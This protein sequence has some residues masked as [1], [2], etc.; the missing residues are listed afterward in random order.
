MSLFQ[1]LDEVLSTEDQA[2]L[3]RYTRCCQGCGLPGLNPADTVCPLCGSTSWGWMAGGWWPPVKMVSTGL[4]VAWFLHDMWLTMTPGVAPLWA[5]LALGMAT[6]LGFLRWARAERFAADALPWSFLLLA[7]VSGGPVLLVASG[8]FPWFGGWLLLA[9]FAVTWLFL[10]HDQGL[11]AQAGSP[12]LT[13]VLQAIDRRRGRL[14]RNRV[15]VEDELERIGPV[16]AAGRLGELRGRLEYAR[17]MLRREM[18]DL[19]S[20]RE[21]TLVVWRFLFWKNC[22][23][24]LFTALGGIQAGDLDLAEGINRGLRAEI[25]RVRQELT[26]AI[27]AGRAGAGEIA[28]CINRSLAIHEMIRD[29]LAAR[30]AQEVLAEVDRWS[31]PAW[32]DPGHPLVVAGLD[33]SERVLTQV[34]AGFRW[35][36]DAP[37]AP[38]ADD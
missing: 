32:S 28:D 2:T 8:R 21:Y 23:G 30:R 16:K 18:T 33:S 9:W 13:W 14:V 35:I 31:P 19:D 1:W 15:R 24:S 12:C 20:Q 38:Q 6:M 34:C 29:G 4:L 36:T 25:L 37:N 10:Q 17:D 26:S 3:R 11:M 27:A 5:A 22:L 7:F